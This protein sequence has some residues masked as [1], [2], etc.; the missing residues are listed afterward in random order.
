MEVYDTE[1]YQPMKAMENCKEW[2]KEME[3]LKEVWNICRQPGGTSTDSTSKA[4]A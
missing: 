2:V 4:G 1:S 3:E